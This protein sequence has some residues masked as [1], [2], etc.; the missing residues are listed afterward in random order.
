MEGLVL[1]PMP[2]RI[3]IQIDSFAYTGKLI[4]PDAVKRL[5]S[6]GK[7]IAVGIGVDGVSLGDHVVVP[8]YSGTALAMRD[9]KTQENLPPMRVLTVDEILCKLKGDTVELVDTSA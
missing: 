9:K 8:M 1:E 7:V 4:I 5:P 3:I 2:G 6:T